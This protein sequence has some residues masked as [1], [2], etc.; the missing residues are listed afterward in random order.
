MTDSGAQIHTEGLP[1]FRFPKIKRIQKR[2]AEI[3]AV[4]CLLSPSGSLCGQKA[5]RPES[6]EPFIISIVQLFA[7]FRRQLQQRRSVNVRF[8]SFIAA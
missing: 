6:A 4:P 5:F 8:M 2:I 3:R 7:L 1:G